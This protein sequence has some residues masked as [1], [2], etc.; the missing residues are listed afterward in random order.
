MAESELYE[1]TDRVNELQS[2]ISSVQGQK[3]KAEGDLKAMSV[4]TNS[5]T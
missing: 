3:R 1:A 2:Q 4:S 5:S